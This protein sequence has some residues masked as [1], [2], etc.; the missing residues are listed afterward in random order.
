MLSKKV[1]I[2]TLAVL[3]VAGGAYF[4][5]S[6]ASLQGKFKSFNPVKT[7]VVSDTTKTVTAS[8]L[9]TLTNKM[10]SVDNRVL[11]VSDI[12]YDTVYDPN[13]VEGTVDPKAY[14]LA[15]VS[16]KLDSATPCSNQSWRYILTDGNSFDDYLNKIFDKTT[17]SFGDT[18]DK[19]WS[20]D[21]DG[22]GENLNKFSLKDAA[23]LT[24]SN[25]YYYFEGTVKEGI[26]TSIYDENLSLYLSEACVTTT[27][28][29]N[30]TWEA[31]DVYGQNSYFNFSSDG[32]YGL[33]IG[34]LKITE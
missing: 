7:T 9:L 30:Y 33:K 34:T 23:A 3:I 13:N 24:G 19:F 26:D 5:S 25:Y 27:S 15:T 12:D 11:S 18:A 32:K 21:I 22:S 2:S 20:L 16:M 29:T 8:P 4:Y 14:S 17:M 1:L 10:G 31:K 28:G 6:G